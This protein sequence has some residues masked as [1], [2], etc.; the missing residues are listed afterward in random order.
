MEE[1]NVAR[2]Q[3]AARPQVEPLIRPNFRLTTCRTE[4]RLQWEVPANQADVFRVAA[5]TG[6]QELIGIVIL[7][8]LSAQLLEPKQPQRQL[9]LGAFRAIARD[10]AEVSRGVRNALDDDEERISA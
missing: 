4:R 3:T 5:I 10:D 9:G 7:S 1:F 6:H 2:Y 8:E